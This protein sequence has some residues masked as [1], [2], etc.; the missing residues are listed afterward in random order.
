MKQLQSPREL[1]PIDAIF[2]AKVPIRVPPT[3]GYE[4][5]R[6]GA[7]KGFGFGPS[8]ANKELRTTFHTMKNTPEKGNRVNF[9]IASVKNS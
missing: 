2:K 5:T 4:T 8:D 6:V 3:I 7:G 1:A 9:D